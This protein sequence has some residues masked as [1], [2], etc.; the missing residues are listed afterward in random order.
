MCQYYNTWMYQYYANILVVIDMS[1]MSI[2]LLPVKTNHQLSEDHI[3][4]IACQNK[5]V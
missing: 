4:I 1:N 2:C 5:W 3:R